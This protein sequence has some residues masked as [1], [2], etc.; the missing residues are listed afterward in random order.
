[1]LT[2]IK[3]T[4]DERYCLKEILDESSLNSHK[5][6]YIY[7]FYKEYNYHR[8]NSKIMDIKG[9]FGNLGFV[10]NK[11]NLEKIYLL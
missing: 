11:K 10:V 1:M 3:N 6:V 4:F 5:N 8:V 7:A 9:A 2:K